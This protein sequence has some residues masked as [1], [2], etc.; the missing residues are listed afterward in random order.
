[1][2]NANDLSVF[3]LCECVYPLLIKPHNNIG[4]YTGEQLTIRPTQSFRKYTLSKKKTFKEIDN[5]PHLK[6]VFF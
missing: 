3:P 2:L 4:V 6:I 1:M 5:F